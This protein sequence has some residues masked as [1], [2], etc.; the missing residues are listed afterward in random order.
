MPS[1]DDSVLAELIG[2]GEQEYL[3]VERGGDLLGAVG[4]KLSADRRTA[5]VGTAMVAPEHRTGAVT[6]RIFVNVTRY[7][8]DNTHNC[9][10]Y[11]A[12]AVT[13]HD[14]SQRLLAKLDT[15]FRTGFLF[16]NMVRRFAFVGLSDLRDGYESP[17]FVY[18][19]KKFP[20]I[21]QLFAP[22]AHK[23]MARA[24]LENLGI[25]AEV[26]TRPAEEVTPRSILHIQS[27][28]VAGFGHIDV[29]TPGKDLSQRLS[30]SL[31]G[32]ME[33]GIEGI[34]VNITADAPL[35]EDLDDDLAALYL[36]FCGLTFRPGGK[37]MLAYSLVLKPLE[38]DEIRLSD[39]VSQQLLEHIKAQCA[40]LG[41]QD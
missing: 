10:Y 5:E 35:P 39:P 37:V 26:A 32:L 40:R 16:L 11:F 25:S 36:V 28:E 6:R 27:F 1:N 41:D 21:R 31:L 4:I 22:P 13:T 30:R 19:F 2:S 20:D 12:D 23:D 17:L 18:L 14:R 29:A 9:E 38:F 33:Q 24:L 15:G 8:R 3:V 34:N 7:I